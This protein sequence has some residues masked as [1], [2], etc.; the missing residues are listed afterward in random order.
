MWQYIQTPDPDELYH[1]WT[2]RAHKY[3]SRAWKKGKWV[4]KYPLT[5]KGYKENAMR[6][7]AKRLKASTLMENN[8]QAAESFDKHYVK[9]A[10]NRRD[11]YKKSLFGKIENSVLLPIFDGI[12]NEST[13]RSWSA[14]NLKRN[15]TENYTNLL[16]NHTN[17]AKVK[18]MKLSDIAKKLRK[19]G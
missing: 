11:Y 15:F 2:K 19:K 12:H 10:E 6:E 13:E 1:S 14:K 16:G 18:K 3:I 17:V 5:G 8:N 9:E 4:Y 7:Q